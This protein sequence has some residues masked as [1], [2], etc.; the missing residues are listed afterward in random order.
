MNL[1]ALQRSVDLTLHRLHVGHGIPP[2]V[3][4]FARAA[5]EMTRAGFRKRERERVRRESEVVA[6]RYRGAPLSLVVD[7]APDGSFDRHEVVELPLEPRAGEVRCRARR[8]DPEALAGLAAL[9]STVGLAAVRAQ[10]IARLLDVLDRASRLWLDPAYEKR[11]LAI[12]AIHRITG[13]SREMVIH[14][15]D[16]EMRSSRKL[17][18]WHTLITEVGDPRVLDERRWTLSGEAPAVAFGPALVAA[19][20]SSNIPALP[21]LTYMRALAVKAPAI[22]KVAT[23][24]PV[25]AGLYLDTL[26]ELCP[27]L[28]PA[29]AAVWFP[30]GAADL[31]RAMMER[32]E[33]VIAYG[34][35]ASLEALA[36]TIPTAA[37]RT[38]HGHRMGVG[39]LARDSVRDRR[40]I[41]AV[42]YDIAVFDGQACLA[43]AVYFVEADLD[44]A[45]ELAQR[46]GAA[47]EE[48]GAWLPRRALSV[49]DRAARRAIVDSWELRGL[50]EPD[51]VRVLRIGAPRWAAMV[52]TG[53]Y[54]PEPHGDRLFHL[55]ALDRL[56]D[57]PR[58]LE[59][60]RRVLQNVAIEAN[61]ELR[62]RLGAE[63]SRLGASR[64]TRAGRMPTPSMM[65]HHDGRL[66]LAD[67][68]RWSDIG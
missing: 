64:I 39:C 41:D 30:G 23:F 29:L 68:L 60:H 13:F 44:G 35:D 62:R 50:L 4:P 19:V 15:I 42:A 59:P 7:R 32:A 1:L 49:P 36:A 55:H 3:E 5:E 33:H 63:L 12:E 43:P 10:P 45:A 11:A 28:A 6:A 21:H 40:V 57:V 67:M 51:S 8:L 16:L 9:L 66:C 54:R 53:A 52:T 20:F 34:S 24:E 56:E 25:F 65:W 26:R 2:L 46:V 37:R 48:H 17:D 61:P 38:L 18:L 31:E 27:E 22:G 14:S 47:L 58:L